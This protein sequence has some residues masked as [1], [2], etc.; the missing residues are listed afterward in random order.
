MRT[1]TIFRNVV[2]VF[3]FVT[4]WNRTVPKAKALAIFCD[5]A[6]QNI[7]VRVLPNHYL[8]FI[9]EVEVQP[10]AIL[11]LVFGATDSA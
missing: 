1:C 9:K 4:T 5:K 7:K 11:W 10:A 6:R 2:S 3:D 8:S